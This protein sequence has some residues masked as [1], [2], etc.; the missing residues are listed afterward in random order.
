MKLINNV[1]L[2]KLDLPTECIRFIMDYAFEQTH[3]RKRAI[4]MK[5]NTIINSGYSR[6]RV[7]KN[8]YKV[9]DDSEQDSFWLNVYNDTYR[10]VI[11]SENCV[12]CGNYR[13]TTCPTILCRCNE[14]VELYDDLA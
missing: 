14:F 3:N 4:T 7:C 11:Q 1:D 6:T 13:E 12:R 5:I 9:W 2:F 10:V 8:F